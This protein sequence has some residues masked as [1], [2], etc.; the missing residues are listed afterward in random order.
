LFVFVLAVF[1]LLP[2]LRLPGD[3]VYGMLAAIPWLCLAL[4]LW[5]LRRRP[6]RP[7]FEGLHRWLAAVG[8]VF[9]LLNYTPVSIWLMAP[10]TPSA[11]LPGKA[12]A[13]VVLGA[14]VE[15]DDTPTENSARRVVRAVQLYHQGLVPRVLFSTGNRSPGGV[16]EAAAMARFAETLGVPREA[17]LLEEGSRTTWENALY[18]AR[19]LRDRGIGRIILVTDPLHM[20]RSRE[21]FAAQGLTVAPVPSRDAAKLWGAVG[22]WMY[23]QRGVHEYIGIAFYRLRRILG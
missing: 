22:G 7:A 6:R 21:T 15:I 4:F 9:L 2:N 10:L 5:S 1:F 20:R 3:F 23:F 19:I 18:S 11:S 13:A 16:S 12:P 14:G 17:I 8:M